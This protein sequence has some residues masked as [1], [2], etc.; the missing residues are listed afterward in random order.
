LKGA[1]GSFRPINANPALTL[2]FAKGDSPQRFHGLR[3]IHL[4][5]SIQ[6]QSFSTEN[7]VGE[8]FRE[9]GVPTP[10]ASNARVWLNNRDLGFYVLKEGFTKDFLGMYFENPKGNLYDGGFLKDIDQPLEKDSGD[11]TKGQKDLDALAT[12]ARS[13]PTTRWESLQKVLDVD[14]FLTYMAIESITWDWDGYPRNRNN[15]RVYH[16]PTS[17]KMIF[18][19]HGLDQMFGEANGP[20]YSPVWGGL[21]ARAVLETP[22]GQRL[23]RE[24]LKSVFQKHY[25]VEVLT[26]RLD[27]LARRNR[28]AVAELGRGFLQH[29]ENNIAHVRERI[30][31]RWQGVKEQIANEQP[32]P[33]FENGPVALK[34]WRSQVQVGE[35]QMNRDVQALYIGGRGQTIASWRSSVV[36]E[37]GRYRFHASARTKNLGQML[38]QT[39]G[40][41]GIRISQS[42]R[43]NGLSG[44]KDWT[45]LQYEFDIPPGG[46]EVTLICES[47]ATRGEAWFDVNS[48]KLEKLR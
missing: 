38:D 37:P 46:G 40:G 33:Q 45:K 13:D 26:N 16:D 36:L 27:Y 8:M 4:N 6:D 42:S 28:E 9:A 30:I 5:N 21:V 23:F 17:D 11:E 35:P 24:R 12:A 1:A 7:I 3:K 39:G 31:A 47:R 41:A 32:P 43:R 25:R 20:I 34:Q 10:R 48:L 29:Y 44:D 14:R 2:S 15:Y 19:P 18:L 22:Q